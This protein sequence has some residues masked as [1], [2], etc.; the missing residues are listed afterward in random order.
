MNLLNTL[1]TLK[2]VK[3]LINDIDEIKETLTNDIYINMC[4][5][6]KM[7]YDINSNGIDN[8]TD[9]IYL[10]KYIYNYIGY[11]VNLKGHINHILRYKI[12]EDIF[13]IK[14]TNNIIN[15]IKNCSKCQ[16]HNFVIIK[17]HNIDELIQ[18][19]KK[20]KILYHNDNDDDDNEPNIINLVFH[21]NEI[22]P[23]EVIKITP[24]NMKDIID[25][26]NDNNDNDSD[27]E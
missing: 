7:I 6:L 5:E 18:T 27:G 2:S 16:K 9:N 8:I 11:N 10:V 1:N 12:K 26:K 3:K 13:Y 19:E 23:I 4:K 17:H 24:D 20:S 25:K 15:A 22:T 14:D 21:Y